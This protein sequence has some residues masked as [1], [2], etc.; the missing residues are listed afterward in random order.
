MKRVRN[1]SPLSARLDAHTP[2]RLPEPVPTPR[3][4][5]GG[6]ISTKAAY[7]PLLFVFNGAEEDS[8][9]MCSDVNC[10]RC[11]LVYLEFGDDLHWLC[12]KCAVHL[13]VEP[14][15]GDGRCTM[16]GRPGWVLMLYVAD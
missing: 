1:R 2:T 8:Q 12:T 11:Q 10:R 6:E 16:C 7:C 5:Q 14:Y 15:W 3:E 13:P 9:R 4:V